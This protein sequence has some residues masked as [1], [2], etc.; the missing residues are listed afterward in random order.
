MRK[1]DADI[2]LVYLKGPGLRLAPS[3][4]QAKGRGSSCARTGLQAE[5]KVAL[6]RLR[7]ECRGSG[8]DHPP[9]LC[10]GGGE[11]SEPEGASFRAPQ[12]ARHKSGAPP[13]PCCA[14]SPSPAFA[15]EDTRRATASAFAAVVIVWV[16]EDLYY[17]G[18]QAAGFAAPLDPGQAVRRHGA[19][20][21]S[22]F[23][24][25]TAATGVPDRRGASA[26]RPGHKALSRAVRL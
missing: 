7:P 15:G 19:E 10:G 2:S 21:G 9:P 5:A 4:L 8:D 14:W 1:R 22:R 12:V 16:G 3:G 20:P 11:R 25:M 17:F 26:A 6:R 23:I 24:L 18:L 13:P